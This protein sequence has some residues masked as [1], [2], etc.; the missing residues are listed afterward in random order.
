MPNLLVKAGDWHG[1]YVN[2]HS[3]G[4]LRFQSKGICHSNEN[5][6]GRVV[7]GANGNCILHYILGYD[8][9]QTYV[10]SKETEHGVSGKYMRDKRNT[11]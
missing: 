3:H 8:T 4:L 10:T 5:T 7:L 9:N 1:I 6:A 11:D 2:A